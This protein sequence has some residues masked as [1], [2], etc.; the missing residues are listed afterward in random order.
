MTICKYKI[1]RKKEKVI[2]YENS[3]DGIWK[4]GA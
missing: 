1:N 4:N 2:V 3:I